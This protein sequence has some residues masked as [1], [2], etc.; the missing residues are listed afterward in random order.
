[1]KNKFYGVGVGPGDPKLVT[2]K[3]IE[4]IKNCDAI[5]VPNLDLTKCVAYK[6]MLEAYPQVAEKKILFC[7]FPMTC[8][9]KVLEE[10]HK[11]NADLICEEL[12][13]ASVAFL[14]LGDPTVYS[15]FFYVE[16]IIRQRNIETVVIN[17]VS[18]FCA[19]AAK[20]GIPLA[21]KN[22]QIKIIPGNSDIKNSFEFSGTLVFM[23]SGKKLNELK[24]FLLNKKIEYD[25]DFYGISNCGFESE[26][27][28][29]NLES[30]DSSFGYFTLVIIKNIKKKKEDNYKFFQNKKC[31][32]FP[33][34]K[35]IDE[36]NFNCLF[37][38]CPLYVLGEKCGGNFVIKENGIKSCVNCTVP[39]QKENY[40]KINSKFNEIA[41][42]MKR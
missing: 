30:L 37:C 6:I 10:S 25:F 4:V 29:K 9:E 28:I 3:A 36:E 13:T 2:Q 11:K 1:M 7:D 8:D 5:A 33:C 41:E 19:V 14:T 17:G 23:K 42:V 31:E 39:H 20:L 34:H 38:Y 35:N 40:E 32:K 12:K 26:T 21:E 15:T 18:S 16:K 22:E 24:E 27:V